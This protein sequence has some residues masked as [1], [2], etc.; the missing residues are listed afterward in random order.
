MRKESRTRAKI[1]PATP[2]TMGPHFFAGELSASG[3]SAAAADVDREADR[4]EAEVEG[5]VDVEVNGA[6]VIGGR[7]LESEVVP[8]GRSVEY[9]DAEEEAG[10]VAHRE[11]G[12][13]QHFEVVL[14][15]PTVSSQVLIS[16]LSVLIRFQAVYPMPIY[17]D[18]L[19]LTLPRPPR[20]RRYH[21]NTLLEA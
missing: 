21:H 3:G 15:H 1:P 8:V 12:S 5:L 13:G 11:P 2:P 6:E 17:G 14:S 7:D 9:D 19:P 20:K 10:N 4:E 16:A 18:P